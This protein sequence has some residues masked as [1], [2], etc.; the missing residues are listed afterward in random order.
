MTVTTESL[1]LIRFEGE[2]I[3]KNSSLMEKVEPLQKTVT[4]ENTSREGVEKEVGQL[5]SSAVESYELTAKLTKSEISLE[6]ICAEVELL[7]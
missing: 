2:R 1:G 3:K 7:K 4:D 6:I 5:R